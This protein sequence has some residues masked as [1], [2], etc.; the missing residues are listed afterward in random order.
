[1][2]KYD[3]DAVIPLVGGKR[4]GKSTQMLIWTAK[5]WAYEKLKPYNGIWEFIIK[6][7]IPSD[8]FYNDKQ[9]SILNIKN[10]WKRIYAYDESYFIADKRETMQRQ[11]IFLTHII[12]SFANRNHIYFM[13]IQKLNDLD[14]RFRDSST[15]IIYII[16]RGLGMLFIPNVDPTIT[17]KTFGF[18]KFEKEPYLLANSD[19]AKYNLRKLSSYVCDIKDSYNLQA[20]DNE[21]ERKAWQ[22]Y[23]QTKEKW[24]S[25]IEQKRKVQ[26]TITKTTVE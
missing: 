3:L 1:M 25:K 19:R 5:I 12:N 13:L 6:T 23:L 14:S 24:Q 20:S 2:K 11:Q 16:E 15:G 4:I 22:V 17:T 10:S 8:I 18:E 9:E 21:L 26:Y 7:V